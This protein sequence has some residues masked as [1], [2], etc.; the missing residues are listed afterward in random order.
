M[1]KL[2]MTRGTYSLSVC[3]AIC[4]RRLGP[5]QCLPG[6]LTFLAIGK[7]KIAPVLN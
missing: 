5:I 4:A 2:P 3:V 7:V 1:N 6:S